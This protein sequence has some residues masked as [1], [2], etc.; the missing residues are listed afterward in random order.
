V[1]GKRLKHFR[2][3]AKIGQGGMGEVYRA[4]D[5]KLDRDVAIKVL[6]RA[7][8]TDQDRVARF[9]REARA[10]ARLNH[11]NIAGVHEFDE[12]D[13]IYF[14]VMELVP[15]ETLADRLNRGPLPVDEA[16][17]HAAVL[18]RALE[19]AHSQ[20]IIHRDL[21]PANVKLTPDGRTK[22]LDFGLAK[23]FAPGGSPLLAAADTI[24]QEPSPAT[25]TGFVIGTAGYMSPEQV[26]AE[27]VDARADIWALGC[28]LFEMLTGTKVFGESSSRESLTAVLTEEPDWDLLPKETSRSVRLLLRRCLEKDPERRLHHVADARLELEDAASEEPKIDSPESGGAS[29]IRRPGFL[30]AA[31]VGLVLGALV[32]FVLHTPETPARQTIRA[33][34][35]PPEGQ[36]FQLH[37]VYPGPAAISPDGTRI[38]FSAHTEGGESRLWIRRL[39]REEAR[40]LRG[41][42]E[43][44]YPFWSPDGKFV[45]FVLHD[46]LKKIPVEGGPALTITETPAQSG[47]AWRSDGTILFAAQDRSIHRV[48]A[49]G[50]ESRPVTSYDPSSGDRRHMHPRFLPDGDRFLYIAAAP[51]IDRSKGNRVMLGSLSGDS[52][53]ELFRSLSKVEYVRGYL[54]FTREGALLAQPFDPKTAK[55]TGPPVAVGEGAVNSEWPIMNALGYFSVCPCGVIVYHAQEAATKKSQLTWYDR[56]GRVLGTVGAPELQYHIALSPDGSHAYVQLVNPNTTG[57]SLWSYDTARERKERLTF[58]PNSADPVPS[59]DGRRLAFSSDRSGELEVYIQTLGR[60]DPRPLFAGGLSEYEGT[61]PADAPIIAGAFPLSW[62]P[63]GSLLVYCTFHHGTRAD[64]WAVNPQNSREPIPVQPTRFSQE[65]AAVSPDG[66]WIAYTSKASGRYEIYLAHFPAGDR[67]WPVSSSGGIR[68]EWNP[69]GKEIFFVSRDYKLMAVSAK[70]EGES[71]KVGIP[72]ALFNLEGRRH[73]FAEPGIYAVAPD[74]ERFLVNRMVDTSQP[75]H[76]NLIVG[77]PKVIRDKD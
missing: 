1:I 10:L 18:A 66:H 67:S 68:P 74:G 19:A 54:W 14:L 58:K 22:V 16:L 30:A 33:V 77:W 76:L 29:L 45:A 4:E 55:T 69:N 9:E 56:N 28:V 38:V 37:P 75:S 61:R 44:T 72:H 35:P 52:D 60:N 42:E 70:L 20:G 7:M 53:H 13:G 36:R 27:A 32:G 17:A 12:Q 6:P 31:L 15:G 41:T 40:P 63:D 2:L 73:V 50:G 5:T 49:G 26:R 51:K 43:A 65:D 21:K 64:L 25:K 59:P 24:V 8:T 62:S 23:F 3:V 39:D 48:A 11:P 71:P 47:G 46:R 34:I 57:V